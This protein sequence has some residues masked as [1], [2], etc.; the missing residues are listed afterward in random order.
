[1]NKY[2][3]KPFYLN[4]TTQ[5]QSLKKSSPD[6]IFFAS[7]WEFKVYKKL[8]EWF[9]AELIKPQYKVEIKPKTYVYPAMYWKADFAIIGNS[10]QPRLLVEAK[11]FVTNDFKLRLK[12]LQYTHPELWRIVAVV[13]DG[14]NGQLVDSS[15]KATLNLE[16][17]DSY[18]HYHLPIQL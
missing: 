13:K 18:I 9:D 7:Q 3:A 1:M 5:L 15:S 2:K 16:A 12:L 10:K 8:L 4:P 6:D 14:V 17:L 11:G